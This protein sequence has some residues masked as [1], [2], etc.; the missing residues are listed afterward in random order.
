M[1]IADILAPLQEE[2][3]KPELVDT[4]WVKFDGDNGVTLVPAEFVS[5]LDPD[6]NFDAN[7][8][9]DFYS[10]KVDSVEIVTGWAARLSAPGYLDATE[11]MGTYATAEEAALAL[12]E[13]YSD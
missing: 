8:Y 6:D 1:L 10:G 11:W 7:V 3:M 12:V 5:G 2:F 4:T 9:Q 13:I